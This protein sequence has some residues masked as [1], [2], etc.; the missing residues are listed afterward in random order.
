MESLLCH[1]SISN[2]HHPLPAPSQSCRRTSYGSRAEDSFCQWCPDRGNRSP[3]TPSRRVV[4]SPQ[5]PQVSP[6]GRHC[7]TTV[8]ITCRHQ[9]PFITDQVEWIEFH[10]LIINL[11]HIIKQIKTGSLFFDNHRWGA[12]VH[13]TGVVGSDELAVEP[14]T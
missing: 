10:V 6:R 8:F 1:N 2:T 14:L 11:F 7:V 9:H 4:M 12:V 5:A 13:H 3:A